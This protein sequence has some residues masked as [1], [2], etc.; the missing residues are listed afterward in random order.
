MSVE[1]RRTMEHVMP[2]TPVIEWG[3][4][5]LRDEALDPAER[6]DDN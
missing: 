1:P 2:T 3:P 4:A 6:P 5:H